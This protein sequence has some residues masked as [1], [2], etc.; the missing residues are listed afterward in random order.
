[1]G[2]VK[3]KREGLLIWCAGSSRRT[4]MYLA[5][6]GMNGERKSGADV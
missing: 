5:V 4:C 2:N 6:K 3:F 1:M